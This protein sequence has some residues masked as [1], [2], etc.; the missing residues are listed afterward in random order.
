MYWFRSRVLRPS[1]RTSTSFLA[2]VYPWARSSSPSK[3]RPQT[4]A[5]PCSSPRR[6]AKLQ[7]A[8]TGTLS[9]ARPAL[10]WH[11][12]RASTR[13][14]KAI[15]LQRR[16][17]GTCKRRR[18]RKGKASS[19]PP[20]RR[21]GSTRLQSSALGRQS[22]WSWVRAMQCSS[23]IG[24]SIAVVPTS[25]RSC[26]PSSTPR[27]SKIATPRVRHIRHTHWAQR[28]WRGD[29]A[30]GTF[31]VQKSKCGAEGAGAG[32]WCCVDHVALTLTLR[33]VRPPAPR[34]PAPR[35]GHRHRAS[36]RHEH[37]RKKKRQVRPPPRS[38]ANKAELSW[39]RPNYIEIA[40]DAQFAFNFIYLVIKGHVLVV[41]GYRVQKSEKT[42][43]TLL[44]R[45][46]RVR[47]RSTPPRGHDHGRIRQFDKLPSA[48]TASGQRPD[49]VRTASRPW[50]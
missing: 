2:P 4:W 19:E 23:I 18:R 50:C 28:C 15:R 1:H 17:Y 7:C 30:C 33:P 40:Q 11:L 13:L 16:W 10:R 39:M 27:S 43:V 45:T 37:M 26:A 36:A 48:R 42:Q 9:D 5:R 35:T 38:S 24:P 44:P 20:R 31:S 34:S 49:S 8:A 12:A 14:V 3:T 32:C 29:T 21:G 25:A 46:D 22:R 47:L 6:P 41:R